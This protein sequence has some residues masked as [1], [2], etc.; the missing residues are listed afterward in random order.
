MQVCSLNAASPVFVVGWDK[1]TS[2]FI[3]KFDQLGNLAWQHTNQPA[4]HLFPVADGFYSTYRPYPTAVFLEHYSDTAGLYDWGKSYVGNSISGSSDFNT[5]VGFNMFQNFFY[6]LH[7]LWDSNNRHAVFD[8]FVT[9]ICF[10]NITS[11]GTVKA[12]SKITVHL[13]LNG[14]APTGGILVGLNCNTW[15]L[16]MPNGTRAQSFTIPA[17]VDHLDVQLS[18]QTVLVNTTATL[19]GISNGIRRGA[20]V[21]VTP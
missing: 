18:A 1:T 10:Q 12:G 19:L 13:N 5:L 21:T 8:R 7:N 14:L 2:Q 16:L 3:E 6:V 9:G 17:G 20:A 15:K 11:A 4:E